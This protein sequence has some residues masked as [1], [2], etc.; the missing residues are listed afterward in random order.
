MSNSSAAHCRSQNFAPCRRRL[1]YLLGRVQGAADALAPIYLGG[2]GSRSSPPTRPLVDSAEV[3]PLAFEQVVEI[4]P[5]TPSVPIWPVLVSHG[6]AIGT[7]RA[8]P[9]WPLMR[10]P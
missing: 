7:Y 5:G 9:L 4:V 6:I 2:N 10:F 3:D 1:A 8:R